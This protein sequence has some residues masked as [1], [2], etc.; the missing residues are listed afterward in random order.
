M[1]FSTF[2]SIE[3]LSLPLFQGYVI[4]AK[5]PTAKLPAIATIIIFCFKFFFN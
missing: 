3:E 5:L 2:Y 4:P 1:T